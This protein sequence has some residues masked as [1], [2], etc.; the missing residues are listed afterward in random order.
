MLT[1]S[2][3]ELGRRSRLAALLAA[4]STVAL[5]LAGCG[6]SDSGSDSG[7]SVKVTIG[8]QNDTFIAPV[9]SIK[10]CAASKGV[11]ADVVPFQQFADLQRA[12]QAGQVDFSAMGY[13]NAGLLL[14][15]KFTDF[16]MVS[17]IGVGAQGVVLRNGVTAKTWS[18]L[19]G[20][21]VG[22]PPASYVYYLLQY[23]AARNGLD[24]KDVN[25]QLFPGAGPPLISALQK[26]TI[27]AMV[28]WEPNL[29]TAVNDGYGHYAPFDL[30]AGPIGKQASVLYAS[31]SVIKSHPDAVQAV[32]DCVVSQDAYF[33]DHKPELVDA[34]ANK[35]GL[36][37]NVVELSLEHGGFDPSIP[38]ASAQQVLKQF[39]AAGAMT[40]QSANLGSY[41]DYSYLEKATGKSA[42]E[43]GQ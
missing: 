27:D 12:L 26:G 1:T 22:V 28:A 43:L 33:A 19:A 24:L 39:A 9:W 37:K 23:Q 17:G 41:I 31:G 15:A 3:R 21:K 7:G 36:D 11:D 18:D 4:V 5:L 2:R 30:Q 38:L 32:V 16:K 25:L 34:V 42:S 8:A 13:Q 35:T 20:L 14:D 29:A 6:N 10:D 40:D